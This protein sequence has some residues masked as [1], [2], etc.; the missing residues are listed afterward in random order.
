[1]N[2]SGRSHQPALGLAVGSV[3]FLGQGAV[4]TVLYL[5]S[6]SA[7]ESPSIWWVIGSSFGLTVSA[8]LGYWA[9]NLWKASSASP[10]KVKEQFGLREALLTASL[11]LVTFSG[12]F[13]CLWLAA[14][15]VFTS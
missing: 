3:I 4:Y 1:M 9:A 12:I 2:E 5:G 14:G 15:G 6:V 7:G 13:A 10:S 8:T 11:A